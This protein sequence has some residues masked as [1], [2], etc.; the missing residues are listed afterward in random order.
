[1]SS[2]QLSLFSGLPEGEESFF[3]RKRTWS[4]SKHRLLL[5]Y[6]QSFCYIL[7]GGRYPHRHLNYVDGFAGKGQ[8][9]G[10]IGIKNFTDGSTFWQRYNAEFE[11]TDG[12]P[13]IA[14]KCSKIFHAE[15]RVTLNCFFAEKKKSHFDALRQNCEP[16]KAHVP[17]SIYGPGD[18][19]KFLPDIIDGLNGFPTL[20]F[21]DT[22][23]VKGVTLEDIKSINQYLAMS[24]GE[25]F[26]LFHNRAVARHARQVFAKTNSVSMQKATMTY[27]KNLTDLLGHGTDAIWQRKWQEVQGSP[28]LFER[29]ALDFFKQQVCSKTLTKGV[30]SFEIK[31]EYSDNRP[32]YSIVVC[33]NM[34]EKSFGELL[35]DFVFSE[36]KSLFFADSYS[37][38]EKFL[39]HEWNKDVNFRS[40]NIVPWILESLKGLPWMDLKDLITKIILDWDDL[41]YLSRSDYRKILID[42]HHQG[43]LEARNLG[44]R[45]AVTS[46]SSVKLMN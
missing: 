8:Y 16:F 4:A 45:G 39:E 15:Q 3:A 46:K 31:R 35:N 22:F 2:E 44:S 32:M 11:D 21:L 30:S 20:F 12:S 36:R 14:L 18:F 25:M 40:S 37:G 6:L 33:S 43:R 17:F 27:A 10:G 19:N 34:P 24:K 38:I 1:M 28:Q 7:G 26:L 41:G 42:L 23:G 29:W 9:G 13:L 5:K